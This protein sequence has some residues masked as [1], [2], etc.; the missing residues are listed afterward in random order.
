MTDLLTVTRLCKDYPIR[1]G[2]LARTRAQLAAVSDVSFSLRRG[3][4]LGLVGESGCGKTTLGRSVLR[5]LEPSSGSVT[6]DGVDVLRTN[7]SALQQLRRRMQ[8][9]FQDPYASLNPRMTIANIIGE[10]IRVHGLTSKRGVN[11]RV[12]ELLQRVGR[13]VNDAGFEI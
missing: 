1:G 4:T 12:A 9:V 6:F 11:D 5:L 3:E 7:G 2:W 8:I 10:G 13:A